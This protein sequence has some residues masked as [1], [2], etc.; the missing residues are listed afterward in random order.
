DP[1]LRAEVLRELTGR[2]L[3]WDAFVSGTRRVEVQ[4]LVLSPALHEQ[5]VCAAEGVVRV[6]HGRVGRRA[7]EDERERAR[8]GFSP[9]T[10]R[11]AIASHRAEDT[12]SL[13]RVDLLL[14]ADGRWRACEVNA[15][16]PGGHNEALALPR[17]A[18]DAGYVQGT[19]PTRVVG[20]LVERLATMA[21]GETGAEGSVAIV[22][23]TAYAEDLQVCALVKAGLQRQG[24]RAHLC[25]PTAPVARDGGVFVNDDRVTA[26]YRFYPTEWMSG[27]ANIPGLVTAIEARQLRTLSSFAYMYSQSKLVMARAWSL[28][29]TLESED[30]AIL[31]AHLPVTL[32]VADVPPAALRAGRETWVLKRALGRVGEDVF[33]GPLFDH[34]GWQNIVDD[35]L[36]LREAGDVWI[37]QRYVPQRPVATPW[38]D[39][40]VT[41]GAY[42]LDGRFAGYFARI[43]PESHV[44]H[45]AL[46]VPV[47]VARAA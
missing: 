8:Y 18:R 11:L 37:A 2:Y 21:R 34:A 45:D 3:V 33:V 27:Q 15:D 41:L 7:L 42:V 5:A 43:T 10:H 32:D 44:S 23:A 38:G 12:A 9:D 28:A 22:Y 26:L 39:R 36:A 17:I 47:F 29:H 30:R 6:L 14:G 16:C 31:A 35:V 20:R 46:C 1:L 25:P 4:P 40:L 24:V 19:D 13:V